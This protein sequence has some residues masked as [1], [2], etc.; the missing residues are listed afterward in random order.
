MRGEGGTLRRR[1][2]N[3][4]VLQGVGG[5]LAGGGVANGRGCGLRGEGHRGRCPMR[6]GGVASWKGAWPPGVGGA[7]CRGWGF[8]GHLAMGGA[9]EP[10]DG[11]GGGRSGKGF[12]MGVESAGV[13]RASWGSYYM[14]GVLTPT[15]N[16]WDLHGT[17]AGTSLS[18]TE[19]SFTP[20][21]DP[22]EHLLTP[23]GTPQTSPETPM[24]AHFRPLR[25][26]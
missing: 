22:T 21:R 17:S 26:H 20:Y 23:T 2:F 10:A 14:W 5:A 24:T 8:G 19:H 18:P 3:S 15:E 13:G 25:P 11:G 16:P 1:P 7:S 12:P 4:W 9:S 6:G